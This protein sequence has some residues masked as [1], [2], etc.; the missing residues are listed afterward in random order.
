MPSS[1]TEHAL[2]ELT[3]LYR[4]GLEAVLA[5]ELERVSVVLDRADAVIAELPQGDDQDPAVRE[6]RALARD[7]WG[8]FRGALDSAMQSTRA[9]LGQ[10]R[11]S[12]RVTRAYAVH[13]PT[14]T[15]HLSEV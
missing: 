8:Q 3:Q 15:R 5:D 7:A 4:D 9:E 1:P 11:K 6:A 10:N 14:G 12:Q 2:R 13:R